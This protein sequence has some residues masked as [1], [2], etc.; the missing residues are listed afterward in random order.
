MQLRG[1]STRCIES[2][3]RYLTEITSFIGERVPSERPIKFMLSV[4]ATESAAILE[5]SPGV[6]LYNLTSF[7]ALTRES[8]GYGFDGLVSLIDTKDEINALV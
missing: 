1:V 3:Q 5:Q 6:F 7:N 4:G 8:F 2:K